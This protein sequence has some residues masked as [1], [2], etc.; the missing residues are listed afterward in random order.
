MSTADAKRLVRRWLEALGRDDSDLGELLAEDASFWAPPGSPWGGLHE[1]RGAILRAL[2]GS[3]P[4]L[5]IEGLQVE[6]DRVRAELVRPEPGSSGGS[7]PP[8]RLAFRVVD[9]RIREIR[10]Y[11]VD[12]ATQQRLFS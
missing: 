1:G 5:E 2:S 7:R 3:A 8:W 11:P 12:G 10:E 9:G 6:D 4:S